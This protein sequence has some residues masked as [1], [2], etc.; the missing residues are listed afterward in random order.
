V[1]EAYRAGDY[2][3]GIALA[4]QALRLPRQTLGDGDPQTLISLNDLAVLYQAQGRYGEAEPLHRE[5]LE[6]RRD[7]LG[8]RHQDT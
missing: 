7:V 5:V 1:T 8:P 3:R 2:P 4:E 6:A